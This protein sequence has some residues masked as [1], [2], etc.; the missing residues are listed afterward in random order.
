MPNLSDRLQELQKQSGI[1]KKD[2]AQA[3]GLSI[4]GY[5]RYERGERE[6]SMSTLI[7]LADFFDVSL[8]YLVGRSDELERR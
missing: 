6:P 4:M 2:I 7:A 1:L 3:V 8:D 5:Y